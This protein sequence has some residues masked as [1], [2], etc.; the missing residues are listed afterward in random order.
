MYP[1]FFYPQPDLGMG[2]L[3]Q[4]KHLPLLMVHAVDDP[5]LPVSLAD[6]VFE[7]AKGPK[8]YLRV[9]LGPHVH[10][11]GIDGGNVEPFAKFI[12]SLPEKAQ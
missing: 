9:S 2:D 6:E 7:Q 12:Q 10:L 3:F 4:K 11:G 1:S 5:L 8:T